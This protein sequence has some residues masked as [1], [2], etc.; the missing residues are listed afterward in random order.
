[1]ERLFSLPLLQALCEEE[2]LDVSIELSS[3][4]GPQKERILS[5]ASPPN[6]SAK[7][8]SV[9]GIFF[10]GRVPA[11]PAANVDRWKGRNVRQNQQWPKERAVVNQSEWQRREKGQFF[12]ADLKSLL[13]T[14]KRESIFFHADKWLPL[15]ES[16]LS[17]SPAFSR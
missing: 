14:R 9:K 13:P 15:P 10:S 1:M 5:T 11:K 3:Q 8:F 4:T 16:S 6:L 7:A 12:S 17:R 2:A